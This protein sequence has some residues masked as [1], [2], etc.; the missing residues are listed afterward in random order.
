MSNESEDRANWQIGQRV[1]RKNTNELGTVMET[2]GKIKV[3]WDDGATSYFLH[4]NHA[5]V[6][7]E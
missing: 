6:E 3:K 7:L 1:C 4:A 5:N 2:D